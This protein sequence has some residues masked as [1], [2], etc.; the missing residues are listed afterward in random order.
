MIFKNKK[1][2]ITGV[3]GSL[4][5]KLVSRILTGEC[6]VPSKIVGFSRDEAKQ[7]EMRLAWK[8]KLTATDEIIYHNPGDILEFQIGDVRNFHSVQIALKD[9]DIVI[10]TSALKQVPTCEYFPFEAVQTNIH[11]ANNIVTAIASDGFKVDTVVGVSTDKACKPVNVMGM[12]KSIQERIFIEGNLKCSHTRFV[13]TRYGNVLASRGSVIPMFID[14]ITKGV[15]VTITTPEMTRFL[16]SLDYAV[17]TIFSAIKSANRGETY[18]PKI[19]S[20]RITDVASVMIGNR[21]IETKYT[22]IRPGE[23]I[24]EVLISE[25]ECYRTVERGDYFAIQPILPELRSSKEIGMCLN[26]EYTSASDLMNKD[27]IRN[28]LKINNLLPDD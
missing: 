22:G 7:H 6:G 1:I 15:P 10:N 2:L 17:D 11:G 5:Q 21:K 23:K 16:M 8:Q 3:T 4:G 26:K 28:L 25:E 24:H 12:T 19:P 13:C 20:A 18:I 27:E 9:V 14:Q